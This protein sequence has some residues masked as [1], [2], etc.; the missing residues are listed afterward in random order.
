MLPPRPVYYCPPGVDRPAHVASLGAAQLRTEAGPDGFASG[1]RTFGGCWDP[2]QVYVAAPAGW[3][4]HLPHGLA[5][6]H[7]LRVD[8]LPGFG[9][10]GWVLPRIL[11]PDQTLAIPQTLRLDPDGS[12]RWEPP[13]GLVDLV[14]RL[15]AAHDSGQTLSEQ[16][17]S[18]EGTA[19]V[20]DLLALSYHVSA[21]ELSALGWLDTTLA[22]QVLRCACGIP[23][24][25]AAG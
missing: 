13:A 25:Q 4:V 17:R 23:P 12:L 14:Q 2:A 3:G 21:V 11:N 15:R 1:G 9:F 16:V 5:P 20:L 22:V 7:L 18:A 10:S 8:A 6:A 24:D 19:L